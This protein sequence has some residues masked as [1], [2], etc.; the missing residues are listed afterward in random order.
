MARPVITGAEPQLFV[1]DVEASSAFFSQKLGF[2]T[3]FMHGDPPFF[4]L[5][6]RDGARLNLRW[7]EEPVMDGGLRDSE[8]LLSAVMTVDS[9]DEID[10]LFKEFQSTGAPFHQ[11]LKTQPWGAK[12]FIVKDLDG[13]LLLFA[14][15]A[16]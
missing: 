3:A 16:D 2:T 12:N 5:V 13:N 14:A 11:E 15:P 1:R 9:S 7:V 8:E 10:Q 4:G 6:I